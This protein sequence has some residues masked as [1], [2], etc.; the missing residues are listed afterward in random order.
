MNYKYTLSLLTLCALLTL[1]SCK[2]EEGALTPS[3]N[4]DSYVLPQGNNAFDNTIV[5]YY[6]KYNS[7][8]LYKFNR[9]DIYWRPDGYTIPNER[10]DS[11]GHEVEMAEVAYIPAQLELI[12][13]SLFD[14][15]SDKFLKKFLPAKI[16][17][18]SKVDSVSSAFDFVTFK[19]HKS[20]VSV[21]AY[22]YDN[23]ICVNYGNVKVT[24]MTAADK[25][26]FLKKINTMFVENIAARS[27]SLPTTEFTNSADYASSMTTYAEAYGRGIIVGFSSISPS[28]D[29][30]MYIR[31]MVTLSETKLNQEVPVPASDVFPAPEPLGILN[32]VIDTNGQI[33]KRYTLV[34]NYFINTYGV[35]LQ[36]IG[37]AANTSN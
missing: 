23:S 18:C 33:R 26:V 21:G 2:K 6:Q 7:Y 14:L 34:R 25:V 10:A 28:M 17:L 16:F 22:S 13:T 12:K 15:Y 32:P 20:A 30:N 1:N 27:L 29:W 9:K 4:I 24:T 31:A 36:T 5:G 11:T 19:Y 37:N 8:L 3:G 35:D